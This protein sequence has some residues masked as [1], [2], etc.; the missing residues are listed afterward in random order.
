[1][2]KFGQK[3]R[4]KR[5]ELSLL[6]REVAATIEVDT[7]MLSKIERGERKA[8]KD[9]LIGLSKVLKIDYKELLILWLADQVYS[10]IEDEEVALFVLK[11]AEEEIVYKKKNENK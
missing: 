10:I 4:D 9:H 1:M 6:L 2:N 8:R 11:V 3:L 7:A 5:E